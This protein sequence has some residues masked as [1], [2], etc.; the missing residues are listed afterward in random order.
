MRLSDWPLPTVRLTCEQ[1][2]FEQETNRDALIAVFGD[3]DMFSFRMDNVACK[4]NGECRMIYPDC[5]LVD[6]ILEPDPSQVLRKELIE[7]G[8]R[9]RK[10]LGITVKP[11]ASAASELA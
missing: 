8:L 11:V 2:G 6:A 5:Y 7:E 3:Q 9:L 4:D 10:E 1:C